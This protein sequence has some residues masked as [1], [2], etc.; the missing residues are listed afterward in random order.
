MHRLLY[1]GLLSLSIFIPYQM[2]YALDLF[3][4]KDKVDLGRGAVKAVR[5]MSEEEEY[6][7]GRA[8]AARLLSIYPLL[9]NKKLTEYVN[10]IGQL[11]VMNSD[12]PFTYGGYHFALLNSDEINA[13]ACPGG[14]ILITKGMVQA[15]RSEDELA[16]VLAH[17][18]AHVSHRDGVNAISKSRWTQ[19]VTLVGTNTAKNYSPQVLSQL[20]GLFEGAIDDVFKTLVVNGY[21]QSQEYQADEAAMSYL[22]KAGYNPSALKDFLNRLVSQGAASGGG[23]LKT[24]PATVDRVK[25]ITKKMPSM[26]V[27]ASQVQLRNQRFQAALK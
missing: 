27:D 4:L 10:S 1:V 12:R 19:V 15:V 9:D 25:N 6:Y 13:F 24:H 7:V 16:A 2:A 17:E 26:K 3:K 22:S 23:I 5:P 11:L 8:V 18:I 14:T 21:G 20:V